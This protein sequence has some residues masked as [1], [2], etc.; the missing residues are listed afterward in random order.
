MPILSG[1]LDLYQAIA[2]LERM[3]KQRQ[4][5]SASQPNAALVGGVGCGKSVALCCAAILRGAAEPDGFSLIG[6]LNIPALETSTMRTFL[7]MIPDG[8]GEWAE[9]KR[10]YTFN[11]G[12]QIVFKHLDISDPKVVGHIRSMNLSAAYIDEAS[13]VSEEVFLLMLGRLRRSTVG[14]LP[15]MIRLTSNP[16]GH[17]WMWRHFFDPERKRSWKEKNLGITMSTFDNPFLPPEYIENMVNLYPPDWAERF[18]HGHFS[19][20]SDLVYKE[21]NEDVH[22]WDATRGYPFFKGDCNPPR[23]WPVIVGMDIGS[24]IDPWAIPLISVAPNGMLFQWE[25]VYGNSLLIRTI[26]EE[27]HSKI[28]ERKFDVAYDYANRQAAL[29][30]GEYDIAGTPAIKEVR[31]GLFKT[32]QY[33]HID[34]RLRHPFNDQIK[35]SPR[36]FI[37]SVC[38]N[39]RREISAY[40]WAKDRAG[41]ASGEPSHENSHSPDAI[42]YAIHTFR[43]LPEKLA[44]PKNWENPAL[45]EAS[46]LYW[47]DVEKFP[48]RHER[49]SYMKMR[50][51][52]RTLAEWAKVAERGPRRFQKPFR[53]PLLN[54]GR[55]IAPK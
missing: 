18:L 10:V 1:E 25:E 27:M 21:Y 51:Q 33:I 15:H 5:I 41:I 48:D 42:R 45:D 11:N 38:A 37:S 29:E 14:P 13:E 50:G 46:R 24:D 34:P 39:T 55:P 49:L 16:A 54:L 17:D 19:D 26:A 31:P 44:T 2:N 8:M 3:P 22:V 23:D 40:K 43:P 52:P 20:F 9:T 35:G 30:L 4:F 12:H 7:E 47:K 53:R 28:G 6:R 36:Y 32:A